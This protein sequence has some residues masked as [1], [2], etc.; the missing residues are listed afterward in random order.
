MAKSSINFRKVSIHCF[1]HNDRSEKHKANTVFIEHS[2]LNACNRSAIDSK[3]LFDQYYKES[4]S[5]VFG[6]TRKANKDNTLLEAIVN[7]NS[8]HT[9][10]DVEELSK[11]IEIRTGFTTLQVSIHMDEGVEKDQRL[12]RNNHHAHITFFTLDRMT[13]KQMFRRE[14]LTKIKLSNL[15][16][17]TAK[18]LKM[19]RGKIGSNALRFEHKDYKAIAKEREEHKLEKKELEEEL[20][21]LR[22]SLMLQN[23]TQTIFEKDDYAKISALKK[24][25]NASNVS[26][27]YEKLIELKTSFNNK[28]L[29]VQNTVLVTKSI[30]HD[31]EEKNEVLESENI[32]LLATN[33]KLVG[34]NSSLKKM[35][36]WYQNRFKDLNALL[37]F[38]KT[39]FKEIYEGIKE[40]LTSYINLQDSQS[41]RQKPKHRH[42]G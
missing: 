30:V 31:L 22:Q 14:H 23:Q 26:E 34:E 9:L 29:K 42:R 18:I 11:E 33:D 16:D 13:G 7:L 41:S 28:L 4:T 1:K 35:V 37:E 19:E 5:K 21:K 2:H 3:I 10:L 40:T 38:P 20:S 25:L 8:Y 32:S 12:V 15:Q 6:R 39:S 36:I 27:C 17:V 24:E